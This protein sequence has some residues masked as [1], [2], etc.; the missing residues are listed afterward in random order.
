MDRR[1]D[2][3]NAYCVFLASVQA[4]KVMRFLLTT[5]P[6]VVIRLPASEHERGHHSELGEALSARVRPW[7]APRV[8]SCCT[9]VKSLSCVHHAPCTF[10]SVF[11][12]MNIKSLETKLSAQFEWPSWR[13]NKS[14]TENLSASKHEK[15][16]KR[17]CMHH[18][19]L[20]VDHTLRGST[21]DQNAL[22]PS[23]GEPRALH[24]RARHCSVG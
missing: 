21:A 15:E 24:F 13:A 14:K 20:M 18:L 6:E 2:S 22:L 10:M 8:G 4:M 1:L 17:A 11:D 3:L 16:G 19:P 12:R 23:T 5:R 9:C 7:T